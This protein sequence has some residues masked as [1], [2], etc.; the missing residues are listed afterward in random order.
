DG[1]TLATCSYDRLVKLWDVTT[2]Q[3]LRTLKDHSDAVFGMAFS[4]DG[5]LLASAAADRAVKVWD[6]ATGLR[7]YTLGDATDWLYAVAWSPD[8]KH[9]AAAGV[10]KSL[11][12][13]EV[14]ATEGKL[15]RSIFAHEGPVTRL[16]YTEDGKTLYS[17]SEDRSVN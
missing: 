7:L 13:W 17:L 3:E 4:P 2:G 14:T 16:R 12:V 9:V 8:G 6:V 5:R 10:D 11:R 1:K 15:V